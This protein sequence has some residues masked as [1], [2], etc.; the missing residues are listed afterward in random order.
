MLPLPVRCHKWLLN[1]PFH[2]PPLLALY[3]RSGMK[4]S[5]RKPTRSQC[6]LVCDPPLRD[7]PITDINIR[8]HRSARGALCMLVPARGDR[9][10]CWSEIRVEMLPL[11]L[12][13]ATL[14]RDQYHTRCHE[15]EHATHLCL[16]EPGHLHAGVSESLILNRSRTR[17]ALTTLNRDSHHRLSEH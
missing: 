12:A 8:L 3:L 16:R 1:D 15:L 4:M 6:Q 17:E 2:E 11:P 10:C 7:L 14:P 9:R 5:R 13:L